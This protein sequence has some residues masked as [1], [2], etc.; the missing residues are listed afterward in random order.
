MGKWLKVGGDSWGEV[1]RVVWEVDRLGA[2]G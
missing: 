2:V 1:D